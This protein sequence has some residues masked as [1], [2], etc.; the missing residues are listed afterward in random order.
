[1][2]KHRL[3]LHAVTEED[4][5]E[6]IRTWPSDI[7]PVSE[8]Y[9]RGVIANILKNYAKNKKGH[10]AHLCLAVC[11][12]D[13]PG[14]ILGWCGLDGSVNRSEPEIFIVLGE[15]YRGKGIGTWCVKELLRTAVEDYSLKSVH[16]GCAKENTASKRA[17]E[18]GGMVQYGTTEEGDPQFIYRAE[19]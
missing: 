4:L 9:A 14:R 13:E 1:M 18:K 17:L 15:N 12:G 7:S 11:R 8:E 5:P 19:E 6:V 16:G 2:E 3:F 10:I